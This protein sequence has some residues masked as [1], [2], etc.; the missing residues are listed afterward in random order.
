MYRNNRNLF[1][2]LAVLLAA[3]LITGI[4]SVFLILV[5]Q[6][7]G[8]SK[9][10]ARADAETTLV[11]RPSTPK[12]N[13]SKPFSTETLGAHTDTVLKVAT[14]TTASGNPLIAS[15]SY[16]TTVKLWNPE[17]S[18]EAMSLA[19]NGR[20]NSLVFM[21][22]RESLVTGSGSGDITFWNVATG[23]ATATVAGQSGRI[24]SLASD[25]ASTHIASGSSNGT[26]KVW[27]LTA[28]AASVKVSE[29]KE[30]VSVGAQIN[31]LAFHPTDS[32][33]L[34]SGDHDGVIQV[35]N[36][37]QA[38]PILTLDGDIDRILGLSVSR[39]GKYVASGSYDKII[40]IWDLDTGAMVQT[41]EGHD[42]VV[43]DVAFSPDGSTLASSSY[44]ESI[45]MWDWTTA[46]ELCT[47]SGHSGFVYT[48]AFADEG[49]ALVSG[50]YDGTVRTWDL[51]EPNY[52]SCLIR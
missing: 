42:F 26:I 6:L 36:L 34:V 25:A 18:K 5:D 44:D 17:V 21:P 9:V 31:T 47:L 15:G 49:N 8:G 27:P 19:Q 46:K 33:I 24:V 41:L 3:G 35:W 16:D 14:Q 11:D 22:D 29:A 20:V 32:Q 7:G 50:G 28:N 23:E 38:E 37:E 2:V 51:T 13:T 40:Q 12:N 48:V 1:P 43:A 4:C 10:I 45:K 30:L 52:E 39:D